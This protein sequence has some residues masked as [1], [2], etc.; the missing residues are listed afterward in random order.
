MMTRNI[1]PKSKYKTN[2]LI[3]RIPDSCKEL[4]GCGVIAGNDIVE[5]YE[6]SWKMFS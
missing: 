6:F 1:S 3:R 2:K 4:L 5:K